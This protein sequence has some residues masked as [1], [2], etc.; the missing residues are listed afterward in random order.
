MK[1]NRL[2]VR[3]ITGFFLGCVKCH[4]HTSTYVCDVCIVMR[5]Y[6]KKKRK[7]CFCQNLKIKYFMGFSMIAEEVV[8]GTAN[9]PLKT[10]VY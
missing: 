9:L 4:T 3:Y 8:G 1:C 7:F 5:K 2:F 6:K 10:C